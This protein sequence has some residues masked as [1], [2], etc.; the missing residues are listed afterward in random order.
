MPN[1]KPNGDTCFMFNKRYNKNINAI[2]TKENG[3]HI[4]EAGLRPQNDLIKPATFY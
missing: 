4:I 3:D 1:S 2:E